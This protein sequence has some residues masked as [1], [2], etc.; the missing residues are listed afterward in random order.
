MGRC[1]G[2]AGRALPDTGSLSNWYLTERIPAGIVVLQLNKPTLR[3]MCEAGT[4]LLEGY[5]M[6]SVDSIIAS[7]QSEQNARITRRIASGN[8][9]LDENGNFRTTVDSD[10]PAYAVLAI[11]NAGKALRTERA[12]L[13]AAIAA[14][15]ARIQQ[16]RDTL[17]EMVAAHPELAPH[18]AEKAQTGT[19]SA[20]AYVPCIRC[21]STRGWSPTMALC[22]SCESKANVTDYGAATVNKMSEESKARYIADRSN[23]WAGCNRS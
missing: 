20:H 23:K 7:A 6:T 12:E 10:S 15:E 2:Y 17:A 3:Q 14:Q 13:V 22:P 9:L 8:T 11:A 5:I 4:E 16:E 19:T 1:W 21:T 18:T